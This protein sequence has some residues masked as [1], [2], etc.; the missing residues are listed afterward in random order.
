MLP[1]GLK[2]QFAAAIR[3]MLR[4]VV[5]QLV[6]YGV[7]Y[8]ALDQ[9]IREGAKLTQYYSGENVCTPSR[10]AVPRGVAREVR[11]VEEDQAPMVLVAVLHHLQGQVHAG[12]G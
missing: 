10:G 6:A 11:T 2:E 9:M 5:R 7:T 1:P 12:P 4:P 8:P 3:R